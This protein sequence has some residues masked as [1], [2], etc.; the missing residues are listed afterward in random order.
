MV[1]ETYPADCISY[2]LLVD[3]TQKQYLVKGYPEPNTAQ[4][5]MTGHENNS[6]TSDVSLQLK[7]AQKSVMTREPQTPSTATSSLPNAASTSEN[8]HATSSARA[9]TETVVEIT[10]ADSSILDSAIN[11]AKKLQH[12]VSRP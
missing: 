10:P 4:N 7:P 5:K 6:G 8:D 9:A 11:E 12:M 1:D 2:K 3:P